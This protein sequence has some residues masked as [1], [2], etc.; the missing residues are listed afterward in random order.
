VKVLRWNAD[1][2]GRVVLS[3]GW[4]RITAVVT[5]EQADIV[6]RILNERAGIQATA[7]NAPPSQLE[8]VQDGLI[9]S[10]FNLP[11][12]PTEPTEVRFGTRAILVLMAVVA[13]GAAG[14]SAFLR[15]F[16]P[17]VRWHVAIFWAAMIV[18]LAAVTVVLA[19][20]RFVAERLAGKSLFE[21]PRHSYFLPRAPLVA[22]TLFGAILVAAAPVCWAVQSL[23]FM[24]P[25]PTKDW[26]EMFWLGLYG[27]FFSGIG[28]SLLWWN[29]RIR[30]GVNGVLVR[31]RLLPWETFRRWYWDA[32]NAGVVVM[33]FQHPNQPTGRAIGKVEEADRIA[34]SQLLA[35]KLAAAKQWADAQVAAQRL[36]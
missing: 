27:I 7:L 34:I 28:I 15:L 11:G 6:K 21:L 1:Q 35:D 24:G 18:I 20:K 12:E 19:R 30:V 5:P 16:P 14:L 22:T 10:L 23:S 29:R 3:C 2:G 4:R 32:C 8:A 36:E 31:T 9:A 17:D 33:E 26:R 13:V 25:N